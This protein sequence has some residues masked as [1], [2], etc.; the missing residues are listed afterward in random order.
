M[1]ATVLIVE[2]ES[3]VTALLRA[4][5]SSEGYVLVD[6]STLAD[7]WKYFETLRPDL[8]IA[9]VGLPDGTGLT[10]CK[11]VRAH[12]VLSDTPFIILTGKEQLEDKE[13]G[14]AA[15]ADH[16]LTKP[17]QIKELR[18]WVASLLRRIK[19][20][21]QGHGLLRV[22]DFLID[23]QTHRVQVGEQVVGNLTRRE[24]DLLYELVRQRP[25]V[26]SRQYILSAVWNTILRDN[27]V[28]VHVR[29][30]RSKLGAAAPR[31][32]TVPGVGYRFD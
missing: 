16:Y 31:V 14:F 17:L 9:D 18:L 26:L 20:S 2:D 27:T 7:G 5:L 25:K 29:N 4:A 28:E 30:I 12:A 11:K 32:V 13:K 6:A 8:V 10:L 21:D 3:D 23:P 19:Y 22:H 24:F 15:G 1:P